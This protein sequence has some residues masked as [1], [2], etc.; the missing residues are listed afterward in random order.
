MLEPIDFA[1]VYAAQR[2]QREG[3]L[4]QNPVGNA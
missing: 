1:A 4:I 2:A 3:A